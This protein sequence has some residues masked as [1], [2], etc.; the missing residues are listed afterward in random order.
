MLWRPSFWAL[1]ARSTGPELRHTEEE[2]GGAAAR[3]SE[4][5]AYWWVRLASYARLHAPS[6]K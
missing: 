1:K 4:P 6:E 3:A 2:E 5:L